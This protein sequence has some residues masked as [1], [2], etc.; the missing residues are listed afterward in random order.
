[1]WVTKKE[2]ALYT[3]SA[4]L[5]FQVLRMGE[6]KILEKGR[7]INP[8][9]GDRE[10]LLI[11][12]CYARHP[13]FR[14]AFRPSLTYEKLLSM[15]FKPEDIPYVNGAPVPINAS[16]A[17]PRPHPPPTPP[18]RMDGPASP[19][20]NYGGSSHTA[21]PSTVPGDL[22]HLTP[23]INDQT[24]RAERPEGTMERDYYCFVG[25]DGKW[26]LQELQT[27]PETGHFYALAP[28]LLHNS[29][30]RCTPTQ[31]QVH[32]T[33]NEPKHEV[34]DRVLGAGSPAQSVQ[35]DATTVTE[36]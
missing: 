26:Y 15:G 1:M 4:P 31:D 14:S 29:D 11:G 32:P 34:H 7:C 36:P 6:Q 25:K 2:C 12:Q 19:P 10:E 3:L 33:I 30:L 13:E 17:L 23:N 8:M 20:H 28:Q 27:D 22:S 18:S 35:G 16:A 24:H 9:E 21:S 5:G